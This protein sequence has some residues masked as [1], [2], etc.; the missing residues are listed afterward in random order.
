MMVPL[1]TEAEPAAD[2]MAKKQ[3]GLLGE[4][5]LSHPCHA[6]VPGY[7]HSIAAGA[8]KVHFTACQLPAMAV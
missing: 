4:W 6:S 2:N 8:E 3:G 7:E 1:D 5:S